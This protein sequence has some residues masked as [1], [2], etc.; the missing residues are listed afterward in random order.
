MAGKPVPLDANGRPTGTMGTPPA[1]P[2]P[3]TM[4][5]AP[6]RITVKGVQIVLSNGRIT[7]PDG[8][9]LPPR[10][11]IDRKS[12]NITIG[13][14]DHRLALRDGKVILREAVGKPAATLG[15][16]DKI[17]NTST[18]FEGPDFTTKVVWTPSMAFPATTSAQAASLAQSDRNLARTGGVVG[19]SPRT[20]VPAAALADL[21]ARMKAFMAAAPGAITITSGK[22]SKADGER[23]WKEALA[24]YGDPE[25]ADNW[26]ARPGGSNHEKGAAFDL[27]FADPKVR[28]WAHANAARFGLTFPMG[29]EPWHVEP[30]EARGGKLSSQ[31]VA[32]GV[33]PIKV[34]PN[35]AVASVGGGGAAGGGGGVGATLSTAA[36]GAAAPKES[37]LGPDG[38]IDTTKAIGVYGS[39]AALA[40]SV[41]DIARVIKQAI[42]LGIDPGTQ[43]GQQRFQA[44]LENTAWWKKTSD[45]QRSNELLKKTNP[46]QYR[47]VRQ[48]TIDYLKNVAGELGVEEGDQRLFIIAERAMSLGWSKDEM[49][50]YLAADIKIVGGVAGG[51]PGMAAVTVDQLKEQAA[52]YLV[53]MSDATLQT[54]TQQV[55]KGQVP[56]EAFGSYLKEQAKSLFPGLKTAI[57]SGVT[58]AQYVS[59]YRE[60]A[61]QTLEINPNE[62]NFLDP[63]WS[64]A[65]FQ[66]GKDGSRTSMSLADWQIS[67]R[68]RP[69]FAK[70]R[71]AIDQAANFATSLATTFGKIAS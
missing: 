48:Q 44:M 34:A 42:D 2:R 1:P 43:A 30:V 38:K 64:S 67:L 63:K 7:L 21:N 5:K 65:L 20:A 49:K 18:K 60:L 62:I 56:L 28:A 23:L 41:P 16:W 26:V 27:K 69:E 47:Q 17:K 35:G 37:L 6:E 46:G 51:K 54:W 19:Q 24:K 55:L 11:L 8:T 3:A 13:G 15:N 59:P 39:V 4:G 53:P 36:G 71:G 50:R 31:A 58:V 33:A 12:G 68:K 66:Q 32:A 29:N 52:Q 14:S 9:V 22:R 10:S 40:A 25:I 45:S 57:D 70:T 61:A